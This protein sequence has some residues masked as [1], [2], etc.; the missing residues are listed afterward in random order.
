MMKDGTLNKCKTC[1]IS[2]ARKVRLSNPERQHAWRIDW[3]AKN[4]VS[5]VTKRRRWEA[6]QVPSWYGELDELAWVEAHDLSERLTK[7]AGARFSVDHIIPGKGKS[8]R[9]LHWHKNWRVI[10]Q[11][12]NSSKGARHAA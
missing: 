8:V 6:S 9:G 2:D 7:L 3:E 1:C 11:A 4:P 10:P 12:A 5:Y